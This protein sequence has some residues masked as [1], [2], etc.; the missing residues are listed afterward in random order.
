[1]KRNKYSFHEFQCKTYAR[2]Y[3][4]QGHNVVLTGQ[5][6]FGKTSTIQNSCMELDKLEI[7]Y[8]LTCS[9]GIATCAYDERSWTLN[10]WC[11]ILDWRYSNDEFIHLM[12]TD[13]RYVEIKKR[14]FQ[15][16]CLIIDEVSMIN[17]KT[18]GQVEFILRK[19]CHLWRMSCMEIQENYLF[20][21]MFPP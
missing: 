18:L 10:K 6:G 2:C 8:A 14:I 21:S 19:L 15:T 9:T 16:Q 11:G 3:F 17:V 13:E 7:K 12:N 1:M 5:A 20:R 4:K